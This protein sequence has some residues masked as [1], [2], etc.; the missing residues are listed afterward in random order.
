M[1]FNTMENF[2]IACIISNIESTCLMFQE[3]R[4]KTESEH[5]D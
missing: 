2:E 4:V 1:S 5:S 3:I